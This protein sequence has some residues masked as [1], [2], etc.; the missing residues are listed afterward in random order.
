[1]G[2]CSKCKAG[3]YLN[4]TDKGCYSCGSSPYVNASFGANTCA[5]CEIGSSNLLVCTQCSNTHYFSNNVCTAC[6]TALA[7]C[8]TCNTST[9]CLSCLTGSLLSSGICQPCST[10]YSNCLY[11]NSVECTDCMANY[12]TV[13]N[14]VCVP[15]CLVQNCGSCQVKNNLIC[16]A[17][18]QGYSL[19]GGQCQ[20]STCAS[21][22]KFNGVACACPIQQYQSGAQCLSCS[23]PNCLYCPGNT[24][25]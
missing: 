13:D 22:L 7:N 1:V 3:F 24:C 14:K 2:T 17:C 6:S 12:Y 21:G 16:A 9:T 23:N 19:V 15:G 18:K 25:N 10:I 5:V 4:A 20:I 8:S 11:C